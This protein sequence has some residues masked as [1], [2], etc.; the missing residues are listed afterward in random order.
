[1]GKL[2]LLLWIKFSKMEFFYLEKIKIFKNCGKL[3]YY[4]NFR[5][6]IFKETK[7]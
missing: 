3:I 6:C 5:A 4:S 1:M 7:F 2:I